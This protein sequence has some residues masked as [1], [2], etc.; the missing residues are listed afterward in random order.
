MGAEKYYYAA[1]KFAYHEIWM[2]DGNL[3]AYKGCNEVYYS[4]GTYKVL[5]YTTT[6]ASKMLLV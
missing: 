3:Y 1:L 2:F 4:P 6:I 5:L